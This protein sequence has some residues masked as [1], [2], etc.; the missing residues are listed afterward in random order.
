MRLDPPPPRPDPFLEEP[1]GGQAE[2]EGESRAA[3]WVEGGLELALEAAAHS[4]EVLGE[5]ALEALGALASGL[6]GVG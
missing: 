5:V 6:D 3:G 1:F 2:E 4:A